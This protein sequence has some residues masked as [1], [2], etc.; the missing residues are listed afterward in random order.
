M[1]RYI[2]SMTQHCIEHNNKRK[3]YVKFWALNRYVFSFVHWEIVAYDFALLLP[4][5]QVFI[6]K[7]ATFNVVVLDI[8]IQNNN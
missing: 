6:W 5:Q 2:G 7:I 3:T 4:L 1:E 8:S